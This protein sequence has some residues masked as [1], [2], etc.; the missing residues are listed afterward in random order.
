ME[1]TCVG[2]VWGDKRLGG[3]GCVGGAARYFQHPGNGQVRNHF[4][5]TTFCT[6]RTTALSWKQILKISDL[7]R[8]FVSN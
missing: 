8:D 1:K 3:D 4:H 5:A 2:E 6:E 7:D